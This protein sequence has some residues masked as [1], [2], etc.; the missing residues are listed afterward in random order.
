[1][2]HHFIVSIP[3]RSDRRTRLAAQLEAASVSYEFTSD[4]AE[5]Y[6]GRLFHASPP[7]A[8]DLFPWRLPDSSNKWWN[9][10][11]KWG[12]VACSL[13]HLAA[14]E[15][16]AGRGL[17]AAVILE[18]DAVLLDSYPV[19]LCQAVLDVS[20][21]DDEWDFLYLGRVG[22]QGDLPTGSSGIVKPGYS[23]CAYGYALSGRGLVKL[24]SVRF[25]KA[26][27]PV[28]EFLPALFMD[29]PRPDVRARYG[30]CLN[31]YALQEDIVFQLPKD[32]WGSDTEDSLDA[33]P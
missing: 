32:H 18:D 16:A 31:A 1:M 29:H 20:G 7:A 30:P 8:V 2:F 5:T 21:L 13:N 10:P 17:T 23:H 33:V 25:R 26:I 22:L 12:E 14:W 3:R 15:V 11:L 19:R 24:L 28:D 27:M 6:D 4:W 9:R